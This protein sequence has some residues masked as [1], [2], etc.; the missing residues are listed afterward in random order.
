MLVIAVLDGRFHA[1][2]TPTLVIVEQDRRKSV[3]VLDTHAAMAFCPDQ[4][5]EQFLLRG[6]VHIDIVLVGEHELDPAQYVVW[7]RRLEDL[8]I[9]NVNTVPVDGA[10]ID[11]PAAISDAKAMPLENRGVPAAEQPGRL[12]LEIG[13]NLLDLD[14]SRHVPIGAEHDLL[15]L[16][17]EDWG[18]CVGLAYNYA[19]R[20]DNPALLDNPRHE[21]R[22][23]H[24]YVERA[25]IVREPAPAL[26]V[27]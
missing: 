13:P 12:F 7:S 19:G 5:G 15:H 27:E 2:C 9:A 3:G 18:L 11:F 8:K 14:R 16:I 17:R 26:H 10:G 24:V 25:K 4:F 20:V 23:V 21:L 1:C 22:H 6:V